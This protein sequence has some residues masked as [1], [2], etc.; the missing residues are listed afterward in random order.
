MAREISR[1]VRASSWN[2]S[3]RGLDLRQAKA[4]RR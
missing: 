3:S 2:S 4:M 1:S